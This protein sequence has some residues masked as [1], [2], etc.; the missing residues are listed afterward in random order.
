MT[1][2]EINN[3]NQSEIFT[4]LSGMTGDIEGGEEEIVDDLDPA[5]F[6]ENPQFH[7]DSAGDDP[8]EEQDDTKHTEL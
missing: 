6:E 2:K 8:S 5:T 1:A 3:L 7:D 4:L